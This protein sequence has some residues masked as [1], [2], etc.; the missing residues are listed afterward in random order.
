MNEY[1]NFDGLSALLV[2]IYGL[3]FYGSK[4]SEIM[5]IRVRNAFEGF[6]GRAS[7][8]WETQFEVEVIDCISENGRTII[9]ADRQTGRT[10][11]EA[12]QK[13]LANQP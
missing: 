8:T 4:S 5:T 6:S 7:E 11:N 3:G 2:R 12:C 10:L 9:K 1:H 13:I